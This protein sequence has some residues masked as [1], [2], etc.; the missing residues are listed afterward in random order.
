MARA[1]FLIVPAIA[2]LGIA[3]AAVFFV[4]KLAV[5]GPPQQPTASDPVNGAALYAEHCASCHGAEL[6]G[7]PDWRSPKPD[8]TLPA[9][10]HDESGHTWHHGDALLF[11]Y[12]KAGG[13]AALE[14]A[15]VSGFSSG[16]PGFEGQLSD[17]EIWDILS[18]IK[19]SWPDRVRDIQRQRTESEQLADGS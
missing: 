8:G 2:S 6:Q 5:S 15:G 13:Q 3:G 11:D 17:K 19:F 16:M 18:F 9:P 1:S 4:G 10:P 12:T 14:A 7:E